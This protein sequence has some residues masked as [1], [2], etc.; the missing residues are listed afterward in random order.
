MEKKEKKDGQ[1]SE[2]LSSLSSINT[3]SSKAKDNENNPTSRSPCFERQK[4]K[5]VVVEADK[6]LVLVSKSKSSSK[7]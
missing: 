5:Q 7:I 2:N 4:S 1:E 3:N 6:M